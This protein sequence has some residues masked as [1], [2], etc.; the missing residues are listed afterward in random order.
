[1]TEREQIEQQIRDLLAKETQ[2]IPLSNQLFR[3]DGLFSRLAAT[4]EGRRDVAQ[5]ALFRQ[6]QGRLTE[7]QRQEAAAFTRAVQQTPANQAEEGY[8]LKLEQ[9]A[10]SGVP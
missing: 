2:A 6:A 9:A 3:P 8:L 4:E 10:P 7:L 1:M 5:S